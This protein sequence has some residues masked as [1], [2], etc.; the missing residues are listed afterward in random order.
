VSLQVLTWNLFHGRAVPD[1]PRALLGEYADLLASWSWDVALLQEVPPWWP[2]PL[3]RASGAHARMALTSRNEPLAVRA[4]VARR[5][6][7]LIKSKGGGANAILVRGP[8]VLEHRIARLRWRPERR[9]VH[10]VLLEGGAWV[11]NLHA[12]AGPHI[13]ARK[14]LVRAG[15]AVRDWAADA[16]ALLGGD[17]NVPDPM[18]DGFTDLGGHHIDRVLGR[19]FTADGRARRLERHGLSDHAPV[20][21]PVTP[22]RPSG[23]L[24][25]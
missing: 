6:P 12:Q 19:G 10:A 14:D 7:D 22:G 3:G 24:E 25:G 8:A 18:I 15:A 21:V 20:L 23:T 1:R 17:C 4:A 5:R 11:A 9:V 2:V 16:P 13:E